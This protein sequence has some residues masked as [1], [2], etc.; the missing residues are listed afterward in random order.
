MPLPP[1]FEERTPSDPYS[2]LSDVQYSSPSNFMAGFHLSMLNSFFKTMADKYEADPNLPVLRQFTFAPPVQDY[3]TEV[4]ARQPATPDEVREAKEGRPGFDAPD[5]VSK[6]VL[7]LMA[8]N[9]DDG[10]YYNFVANQTATGMGKYAAFGGSLAGGFVDVPSLV[11]GGIAVKGVTKFTTPF[12]KQLMERLAV[13]ETMGSKAAQVG[14]LLGESAIHGAAGFGGYQAT[15]EVGEQGRNVAFNEPTSWLE[16]LLR[17]GQSMGY[18]ALFGGGGR[19]VGIGLL[20]YDRPIVAKSAR[21]EIKPSEIPTDDSVLN[22][23]VPTQEQAEAVIADHR[24][25]TGNKY[26]GQYTLVRNKETGRWHAAVET[27]KAE[28]TAPEASAGEVLGYER[29]GGLLNSDAF[30]DMPAATKRLIGR[31]YKPWSEDAD[32]TAREDAIGQGMNGQR[33]DVSL[34]LRQ[35]AIDE[36]VLFRQIMEENGIDLGDLDTRLLAADEETGRL[37]REMRD[38]REKLAESDKQLVKESEIGIKGDKD[39]SQEGILDRLKKAQFKM[40]FLE[41]A[42]ETIPE[43]LQKYAELQDQ[44]NRLQLKLREEGDN[45]QVRRRIEQLKRRQPKVESPKEELKNLKKRLLDKGLADDFH[46][47]RD[48]RRLVDLAKVWKPARNL[49]D[50]VHLEHDHQLHVRDL[51]SRKAII[52]SM[53][54]HINGTHEPVTQG[55]MKEYANRLDSIGVEPIDYSLP[56][57]IDTTYDAELSKFTESEIAQL[58]DEVPEL[59]PEIEDTI[60]RREAT[61]KF[62]QM[63]KDLINCIL[64]TEI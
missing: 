32:I 16:S 26:D 8:K 40:E 42:P 2:S 6:T 55:D 1:D 7:D 47:S 13:S 23:D 52:D 31:V 33:P 56:D 35:G 53:R 54:N 17:V 64:R 61:P 34:T 10:A 18:G 59:R 36:G 3:V 50:R 22:V 15:Q 20:G 30:S 11:G 27:K 48:Y 45:K 38:V 57:N 28:E 12:A 14:T 49:L 37:F 4:M 24:E 9:W 46:D 51:L 39:L 62:K 41:K 21:P 29:V 5:G 44:I 25:M 60:R 63:T 19:G 43:N 58:L